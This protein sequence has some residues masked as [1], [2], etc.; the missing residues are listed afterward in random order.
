[1]I[2]TTDMRAAYYDSQV[3][4]SFCKRDIADLCDEVDR[5]RAVLREI[6]PFL[7][8]D[9]GTCMTLEYRAA[10]EAVKKEVAP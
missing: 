2:D 3:V 5:L 6:W 7:E 9:L 10:V 8:E 1:M 4:T